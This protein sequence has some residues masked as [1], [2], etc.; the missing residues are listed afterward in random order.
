MNSFNRYNKKLST[1]INFD[2]PNLKRD[3]EED[4]L[5]NTDEQEKNDK[6]NTTN[7]KAKQIQLQNIKE[8]KIS[9]EVD[10][11]TNQQELNETKIESN[12][13]S[14]IEQSSTRRNSMRDSLNFDLKIFKAN[15]YEKILAEKH[16]VISEK[17]ININEVDEEGRNVLHRAALQ[18][19][20][21]IVKSISEN[22]SDPSLID[23]KDKYGNTA[24][25]LTCKKFNFKKDN[26]TRLDILKILLKKGADVNIYEPINN[27]TP[28]HW[29]AFNGDENSFSL[30]MNRGAVYFIPDKEGYF[31]IDL[32]GIKNYTKIVELNI[33]EFLKFMDKIGNFDFLD[34]YDINKSTSP[35]GNRRS[36]NQVDAG[37]ELEMK[38]GAD[39]Y[40]QNE[41][42]NERRN[43][44]NY[45]K[46]ENFLKI[47]NRKERKNKDRYRNVEIKS[48]NPPKYTDS[49]DSSRSNNES[50]DESYNEDKPQTR[51]KTN[52]FIINP[53]LQS[54][55]IKNFSHHCLYW[56]SYYKFNTMYVNK[57]ITLYNADPAFKLFWAMSQ[58]PLHGA[59]L[60]GNI[61]AFKL[62]L[63]KYNEDEIIKIHRTDSKFNF[64]QQPNS[65]SINI[66][67]DTKKQLQFEFIKNVR[68]IKKDPRFRN[69]TNKFKSYLV[70]EMRKLFIGSA[71]LKNLPHDKDLLHLK[72]KHLNTPLHLA[73]SNG[74]IKFLKNLF[75]TDL[76][77]KPLDLFFN[78]INNEG[79]SGYAL[80]KEEK[81]KNQILQNTGKIIY[82]IPLVVLE[83]QNNPTSKNA[84]NLIM[85]L[86]ITEKLKVAL[87]EHIDNTKVY[88]CLDISDD[89]FKIQFLPTT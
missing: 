16:L 10:E 39:S 69:L 8:R 7:I 20:I 83:L 85:K 78:E 77:E 4:K 60:N 51:I 27:W 37:V 35:L 30:L 48:E 3:K 65:V 38:E 54:V 18:Q 88:I 50:N 33:Q 47:L 76:L 41:S 55:L 57:L 11:N 79:F 1:Y 28:L 86:A 87:M 26:A 67:N 34:P 81:F 59:C 73:A 58:T 14:I 31:P 9:I 22:I 17:T 53:I 52:L 12:N 74:K 68:F 23:R 66:Q 64:F 42:N 82:N 25:L 5:I 72:D 13:M 29:L 56:A 62:L 46:G 84:I 89:I 70:N 71:G 24:L 36:S 75:E 21:D 61:M 2:N 44:K 80:L 40:D 6:Y 19:K 43:S 15:N 45:N 63:N 32:A 49:S